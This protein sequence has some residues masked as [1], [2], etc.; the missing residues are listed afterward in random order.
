MAH[1]FLCLGECMVELA[2]I[3]GTTYRRGFAGD[4]FNAAWYA[5]R[6]LPPAWEVGFASA[7]GDD[8]LSDEMVGF[9][10]AQDIDTS[11]LRRVPGGTV[12]LY[13]ISLRDGERSFSYW[14]DTSAARRLAEDGDWL[15]ATLGAARHVHFSG[16]TVA[17]LPPE[18][19]T[20]LFEALARVRASGTTVS[21]DTNIRRRLWEGDAPMRAALTRAAATSEGTPSGVRDRATASG[22]RSASSA[23]MRPTSRYPARV[24]MTRA[25]VLGK[26]QINSPPAVAPE[27]RAV[28]TSC[29]ATPRPRASACTINP[30]DLKPGKQRAPSR[31]PKGIHAQ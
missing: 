9:M 24:R 11:A 19:R 17:I 31:I 6:A 23:S 1:R 4:T 10:A 3:D 7:I 5:R 28:S 22:E 18:G 8:A 30:S 27:A 20:R 16:I 21:F 12:G 29:R 25:G 2:Q 14:R 15:D 26:V 13:M